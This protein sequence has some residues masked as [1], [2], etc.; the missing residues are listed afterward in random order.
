MRLFELAARSNPAF[1]TYIQLSAA[2]SA[3]RG[4]L[5]ALRWSDVDLNSGVV[6][7]RRGIV[8]GLD[9]LAEK[10][11]K[12]HAARR[13]AIDSGTVE[14]LRHH[15]NVGGGVGD[16]MRRR[17][18]GDAFVFSTSP[19]GRDNW[20]PAYLTQAFARLAKRAGV[21]DVRLH[22]LRHFV[23]TRLLANGVDVRTV[24]GRLGHRNPNVTLNVYAHFLPEAD[25]DAADLLG[26]LLTKPDAARRA[27]GGAEQEE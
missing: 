22:D 23:A 10:D 3:P 26:R 15:R 2:T 17:L 25:R 11:T 14:S 12:T 20:N 21:P 1:A 9:G 8:H 27:T 16:R 13:I 18:G 19:D 6:R 4:E 7:I 24:A 5:V